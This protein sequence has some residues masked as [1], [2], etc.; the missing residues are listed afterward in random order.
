MD[1]VWSYTATIDDKN[2]F[3]IPSDLRKWLLDNTNKIYLV[4]SQSEKFWKYMKLIPF[5]QTGRVNISPFI[6][7]SL[8]SVQTNSCLIVP[9]PKT[10]RVSI[11]K[12]GEEWL[13]SEAWSES[14]LVTCISLKDHIAVTAKTL[15]HILWQ[16][17]NFKDK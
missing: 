13:L 11:W 15:N 14:K 12:K 5:K 10:G 1:S 8:D 4:L 17:S 6:S 3:V 2:R 9:M 7:R 16:D